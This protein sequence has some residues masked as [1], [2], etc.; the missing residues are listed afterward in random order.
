MTDPDSILQKLVP[1][2][3]KCIDSPDTSI[4][5][6]ATSFYGQICDYLETE[7]DSPA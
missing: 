3:E 4:R 1:F 5:R 2:L 7:H 6:E